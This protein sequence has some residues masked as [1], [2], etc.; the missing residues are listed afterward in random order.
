MSY[1]IKKNNPLVNLKLTDTGRRNLSSGGLNFSTF[2]LGDGEMDYTSDNVPLTNIL[3]PVDN[4]HDI[5]S[6]V[7]S[8]G[9]TFRQPITQITSFPQVVHASA[10]TR[11]FFSGSTADVFEP[12][13]CTLY[14]LSGKIDPNTTFID[15]KYVETT[16]STEYVDVVG[17]T[18]YTSSRIGT[19]YTTNVKI[20]DYLFLKI[21]QNGFYTGHTTNMT[22]KIDGEYPIQ[23]LM[24]IITSVDGIV[25]LDVSDITNN[26][27]ITFGLDRKLPNFT[28]DCLVKGFIYPGA[29]T[30]AD[31]YD[32]ETPIAYWSNSSVD[33]TPIPGQKDIID[34]PVWNMNIINI[35]DI[36]GLD[37]TKYKD[38]NK[39][40]GKNYLGTAINYKY[41]SNVYTTVNPNTI[42]TG[43]TTNIETTGYTQTINKIGIIHYTN[44][45]IENF[46]GEGFY[47][48]TLTL[49][50]P[51]LMWH[52]KQFGGTAL[53]DSIGY[54][55]VCDTTLKYID[56]TVAY[57]DLID[58]ES[59]ATVVGKVLVDQ[60]VIII[61]DAE[62]ITALSYKSNRNW[63][64]PK[65]DISLV[66][67]GHCPGANLG[68]SLQ[69]NECIHIT[70][71]FMNTKGINGIQCE[72]YQTIV[73]NFTKAKDILFQFPKK[74]S[75]P[76]Y[77]EFGYLRDFNGT[78]GFGFC[79][80]NVFLLWQKTE[81]GGI[82][83]PADWK[84]YNISPYVGGSGCISPIPEVMD[85]FYLQTETNI[86]PST[87][88][89]STNK[90][91]I[92]EILVFRSTTSTSGLLL[93][94]ASSDATIGVDG[95]YYVYP[96]DVTGSTLGTPIIKINPLYVGGS[97]I[98]QF[99]YLYGETNTSSTVKQI[100]TVPVSVPPTNT[101]LDGIY[102]DGSGNFCLT[103]E[104]QP[105]NNTVYV[106]YNGMLVSSS[107]YGVFTTGT[108]ADR[109]VQLTFAPAGGALITLLYLDNSGYGGT[110]NVNLMTANNIN[111]LKVYV[112]QDLIDSSLTDYYDIGD[113]VDLPIATNEEFSFGDEVFFFGNVNTDIKATIYKTLFTFNVIPNTFISTSN[114][115]FNVNQDKVAFTEVGIYDADDD[116]VAIGKFSQPI[117]RKYNSD[118][119]SLQATIDF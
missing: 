37:L 45:T 113:I 43:L 84:K 64:L 116:M 100:L 36:V 111:N 87:A 21:L 80:D 96:L 50:I 89:L 69:P 15:L 92:G 97:N 119:L 28:E 67:I 110:P 23:Y 27:V 24:Y 93:K 5:L 16:G 115:T 42:V 52:K 33:F 70:Y 17:G 26:Q 58:Q 94:E 25:S 38:K 60:K 99:A 2:S 34:V 88:V 90:L 95:D 68:G 56:E 114:P 54:T 71:Q 41:L 48:T 46:Y 31:Y 118:I 3:R 63:T 11:G 73:N 76:T 39:S 107:N 86:S 19:G 53:A 61:E 12:T 85:R 14:N 59:E 117:T 74:A 35:R 105:N 79:L 66:D 108:T 57:Y 112:D 40:V 98:I 65:P 62:L 7:P 109:R 55:F 22:P 103:L 29:N 6:P 1:I 75:D 18:G 82:P 77:S 83:D 81:I 20:G 30:I 106:F 9:T 49:T 4:N 102:L 101:Y 78:D 10:K 51:Y 72:S 91:P 104:Q 44:N 32:K 13:L 8:N 47:D